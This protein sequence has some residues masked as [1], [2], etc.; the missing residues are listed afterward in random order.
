[1]EGGVL[2]NAAGGSTGLTPHVLEEMAEGEL[3]E[4]HL[5]PHGAFPASLLNTPHGTGMT[6]HATA[7]NLDWVTGGQAIV[8]EQA[9]GQQE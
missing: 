8:G 1:M 3:L 7:E 2:E 4:L 6:P 5:S 9:I